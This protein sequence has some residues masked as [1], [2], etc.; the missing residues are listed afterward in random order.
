VSDDHT[1]IRST[2]PW[3]LDVIITLG[4]DSFR[5]T[6]DGDLTLVDAERTST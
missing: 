1:T 2:D 6:L 4:D 3:Q 5:V